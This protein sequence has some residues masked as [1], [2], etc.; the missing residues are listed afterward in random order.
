MRA[1][2]KWQGASPERF[3]RRA[4]S[5]A[6]DPEPRPF[7]TQNRLMTRGCIELRA[8][9]R[10]SRPRRP[11]RGKPLS[12]LAPL[13][14]PAKAAARKAPPAPCRASAARHPRQAPGSAPVK[15]ASNSR[16]PR[17]NRVA[18][19]TRNA[20]RGM[21]A[22]DR[23]AGCEIRP[24]S[25]EHTSELQSLRHLVCRLLLEK[26]KQPQQPEHTIGPGDERA[27]ELPSS[28]KVPK[29]DDPYA[30]T[31]LL[32]SLRSTRLRSSSSERCVLSQC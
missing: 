28:L 14:A 9:I 10:L 20:S 16:S 13:P 5:I 22:P 12:S 18:S 8:S 25:E 7:A 6:S 26:Q 15:C 2:S 3:P 1:V 32:I 24:R 21:R 11:T 17:R 4:R 27:D 30:E 19:M 31:T 29:P 23:A